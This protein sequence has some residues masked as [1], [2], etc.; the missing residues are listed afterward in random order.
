MASSMTHEIENENRRDV[1]FESE[2]TSRGSCNRDR[3]SAASPT[4]PRAVCAE[5]CEFVELLCSKRRVRRV[6]VNNMDVLEDISLLLGLEVLR[7]PDS[8]HAS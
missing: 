6:F 7:S 4:S 3:P 8:A 1:G 5:C 2:A